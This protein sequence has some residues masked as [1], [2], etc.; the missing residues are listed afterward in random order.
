M[1]TEEQRERVRFDT[2]YDSGDGGGLSDA[3]IDGLYTDAA[4]LW[5]TSTAI[6]AQVRLDVIDNLLMQAAKRVDYSQNESSEKMGQVFDHLYKAREKFQ[7]ALD[8]ETSVA[9]AAVMFGGL[10]RYNKHNIQVPDDHS[11]PFGNRDIS[12]FEGDQS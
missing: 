11:F 9:S 2:G 12:R 1:A 8:L 4:A 10:R 3:V 7:K 5:G 6:E